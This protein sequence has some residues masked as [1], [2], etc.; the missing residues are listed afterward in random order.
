MAETYQFGPFRLDAE[1]KSLFKSDKPV[2]LT[3]KAIELLI[4]LVRNAGSVVDKNSLLREVWADTAVEEGIIAVNIATL[5]KVF[6]DGDRP[7]FIETVPRRGYRFVAEPRHSSPP[8]R[9]WIRLA[10]G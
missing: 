4:V 6:H 9:R 1:A 2:P 5:R 8:V 10:I 3:P 7:A